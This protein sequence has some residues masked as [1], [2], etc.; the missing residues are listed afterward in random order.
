MKNL[1]YALFM[2]MVLLTSCTDENQEQV[3]FPY[4][5]SYLQQI[6]KQVNEASQASSKQLDYAFSGQGRIDANLKEETHEDVLY[7]YLSIRYEGTRLNEKKV[8][9]VFDVGLDFGEIDFPQHISNASIA[10]LG[11]Q[12]IVRDLDTGFNQSFFVEDSE[13][14]LNPAPKIETE[15]VV[16]LR[17][18]LFEEGVAKSRIGCSCYCTKCPTPSHACIRQC[19]CESPCGTSCVIRCNRYTDAR[20]PDLCNQE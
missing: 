10:F 18:G 6:V 3:L 13:D 5:E 17:L 15:T 7:R 4:T 20:C 9:L 14:R 11:N 19:S 8:E 1:C 2:L 16:S 12:L